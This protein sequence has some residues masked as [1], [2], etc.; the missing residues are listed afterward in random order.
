M[1]P[2][3]LLQQLF[4]PLVLF[5]LQSTMKIVAA[6]EAL[7]DIAEALHERLVLLAVAVVLL[8]YDFSNIP[9][10]FSDSSCCF[11]PEPRCI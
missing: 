9:L 3:V 8:H 6:L 2:V 10:Q 7:V 11:P 5:L 1:M 4:L